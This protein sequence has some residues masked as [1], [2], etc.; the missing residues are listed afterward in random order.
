MTD[1]GSRYTPFVVTSC[2]FKMS[3]PGRGKPVLISIL[4]CSLGFHAITFER[5]FFNEASVALNPLV[6]LFGRFVERGGRKRGNRQ[7]DTDTHTHRPSNP[8]CAC[9]PSVRFVLWSECTMSPYFYIHS[10]IYTRR[11]IIHVPALS[12]VSPSC[13]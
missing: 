2:A 7:T 1:S 13:V 4:A 12:Q 8:R 10:V 3:G 11:H 6:S 5:H 9:A